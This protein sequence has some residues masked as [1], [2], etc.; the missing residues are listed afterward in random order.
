MAKRQS[1]TATRK[2]SIQR[3]SVELAGEASPQQEGAAHPVL[4]WQ[5]RLGN[6][7]VARMLARRRGD[8]E[9]HLVDARSTDRASA[10]RSVQA[11]C[12]RPSSHVTPRST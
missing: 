6:A 7:E 8:D 12:P 5:Q 9:E 11:K 1:T 2:R 3:R 4:Q 10:G